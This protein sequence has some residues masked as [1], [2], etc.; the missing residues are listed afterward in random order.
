[1]EFPASHLCFLG[2]NTSL[3]TEVTSEIFHVIMYHE[4]ALHSNLFLVIENT[5]VNIINA[6]YARQMTG[7]L[8]VIPSNI[9]RLDLFS[10]FTSSGF[11]TPS[12]LI[13]FFLPN[14]VA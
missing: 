4:E 1:M 5:V 2:N 7:R 10:K 12:I 6:T 11:T 8:D 14:I 3:P 13:A 9:Q